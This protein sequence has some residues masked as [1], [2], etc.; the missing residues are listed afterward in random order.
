[1]LLLSVV[2]YLNGVWSMEALLRGDVERDAMAVARTIDA[3]LG[4]NEAGLMRLARLPSVREYVR[5]QAQSQNGKG[6]LVAATP[7]TAATSSDADKLPV[8]L[9]SD[10]GAFLLNNEKYYTAI[11]CLSV[12]GRPLFRAERASRAA[13][14]QSAEAASV[15]FQTEDFLSGEVR[16]DERVWKSAEQ[17]PLRLPIAPESSGATVRYTVPVFVDGENATDSRGALLADLKLNVLLEEA[18]SSFEALSQSAAERAAGP[19]SISHLVIVLDRH[20]GRFIYHTNHALQYQSINSAMPS[21]KAVADSM[22]AGQSGWKTYDSLEGSTRLA[23]YRPIPS[24]DLSLAVV[25]NYTAA[26]S[27][28]RRVGW[29]S[30]ILSAL[31]GLLTALLL[32]LVVRR[33]ARSIERVT[34]GAVAIAG[35]NLEQRIEVRSSDETHLLAESFNRMTDRLREQIAREAE[36]RQ[37]QSF[38]RLSAMLTHDLKNSISSL[39]LLVR[40]MER[41]FH[42]EEFRADAM[43]S[44][45]EATDNLRSL[46][47]KLSEPVQSLSGEHQ[48]PRPTDLVP[49]IKRVLAATV[50]AAGPLHEIE[51]HLPSSLVATVEADRIEKVFENLILN[52]LEA[53]GTKKGKLTVEAGPEAESKIF[54]S[55]SDTGVGISDDFQRTKLFHAFATTKA[56][57]VGLGLYT[58]REVVKAHGGSIEVKS[59]KGVG[60]TFRI[61]LPSSLI[62]EPARNSR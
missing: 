27:G 3:R 62:A 59:Q 51:T 47:A 42:N 33:T 23:A 38:M 55:V 39:S 24:L 56:K 50:E 12:A 28:L 29:M 18:A 17:T 60:T 54:F 31:V 48:R 26:L 30:M 41:Q 45:K 49:I 35:G 14:A 4:A 7:Q 13:D 5:G 19:A 44:L 46:V 22:M 1:M 53:M 37:F 34:E 52:A 58:C 2:N 43:L 21:F 10:V 20:T 61:V 25:A 8:D 15:R 40:N 11:T 36:S 16:P 9:R 32:T 6:S 57:G